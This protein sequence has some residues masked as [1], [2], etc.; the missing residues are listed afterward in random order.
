MKE[1]N[2]FNSLPENYFIPLGSKNKRIYIKIISLLYNLV[3]NGL[4]YGVEKEILVSEIEDYFYSEFIDVYLEE[5]EQANN[6]RD[7]A[8]LFIRKLEEYKWVYTETTSDY[9]KIINFHDYSI[10]IIEAFLKIV[11]KEKLEYQG[12]IITIYTLLNTKEKE[13]A[14]IIIKQIYENTKGIISGLK[15]L[16][17]NIK[18]YMDN[19]TKQMTSKQILEDLFGDYTKDV[20]DKSY[21]RLKTS[22]NVSRYRPKIVEKLNNILSDNEFILEAAEFYKEQEGGGI[23]LDSKEKVFNIIT[24]IINAFDDI[25]YIISDID[26]K[27][28][29]YIRAAITR[30]KFLLNNSKDTVGLIKSILEYTCNQYKNLNLNLS[31][32]Y[33]EELTDLFNIYSYGYFD[34]TSFYKK[35]EAQKSFR[36]NSIEMNNVS[37]EER[38]R[39]LKEF[40]DKQNERY[41]PKKINK[42]VLGILGQKKKINA[43]EIDINGLDDY[44][45]LIYIRLYEKNYFTDYKV[46]RKSNVV[47]KDGYLYKDFEIW[48]EESEV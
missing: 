19:V 17:A 22:E 20:L 5:G 4:S 27:N 18:K 29:K 9:K 15:T 38:E 3:E 10:T 35:I 42:I 41:S 33:L 46:V 13:N 1:I 48:R 16:N 32:E 47:N 45:K 31:E 37:I 26:S 39:K 44:I 12:N 25:D 21:H 36:P 14:G 2:I 6:N 11:N 23:E 40:K 34:E 24:S 7:K 28:S 8:N 30:A 43:S